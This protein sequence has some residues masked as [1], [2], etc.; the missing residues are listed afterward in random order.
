MH[1]LNIGMVEEYHQYIGE[2]RIIIKRCHNWMAYTVTH[3]KSYGTYQITQQVW[4]IAFCVHKRPHSIY[5]THQI[6]SRKIKQNIQ[7]TSYIIRLSHNRASNASYSIIKI[8]FQ[9]RKLS[10]ITSSYFHLIRCIR[11]ESAECSTGKE[12]ANA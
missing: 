9:R 1:H 5:G 8:I 12:Y 6:S 11:N 2:M 3:G 4:L 10:W 7:S